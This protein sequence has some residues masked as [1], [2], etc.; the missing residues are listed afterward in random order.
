MGAQPLNNAREFFLHRQIGSGKKWCEMHLQHS[1]T[2]PH[3]ALR[4]QLASRRVRFATATTTTNARLSK[5]VAG[6]GISW[7]SKGKPRAT[8]KACLKPVEKLKL[9]TWNVKQKKHLIDWKK[10]RYIPKSRIILLY[11]FKS[12]EQETQTPDASVWRQ[13]GHMATWTAA[14][15]L[16]PTGCHLISASRNAFLLQN[17]MFQTFHWAKM[18]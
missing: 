16:Q 11:R 4:S 13:N 9:E 15:L 18:F 17:E 12:P 14:A 3:V 8:P 2:T 1:L 6:P 10:Q 7:L 5:E